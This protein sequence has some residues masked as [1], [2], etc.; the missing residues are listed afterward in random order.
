MFDHARVLNKLN[1]TIK[2]K[3]VSGHA[4]YNVLKF[5]M[6]D[7][8]NEK[9]S[10]FNKLSYF[11]MGNQYLKLGVLVGIHAIVDNCE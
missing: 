10:P 3:S 9:F 7:Q 2:T 4:Y 1:F 6:Q 8:I 11:V 5:S